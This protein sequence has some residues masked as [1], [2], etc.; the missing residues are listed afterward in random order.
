M[1]GRY[2]IANRIATLEE[3]RALCT[4]VGWE[5]VLNFEA[6]REALPRSLCGVV[7]EYE[8]RAVG[9]GRVVGDGAIFYYL[10]DI[11]VMPEHQGRGVGNLIVGSLVE[12]VRQ[13]APP[14][15]FVGVFAASG[16]EEFYEQYG[17]KDRDA[18]TG[19]FQVVPEPDAE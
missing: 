4:A 9:M 5:Q 13:M 7:V 19:M 2:Q 10:Q 14:K 6:A 16:T 18:L 11:A 15:S 1:P 8:G 3:Y 12:R 17:F